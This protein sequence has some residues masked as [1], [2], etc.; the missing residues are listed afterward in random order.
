M[1]LCVPH[2]VARGALQGR[3]TTSDCARSSTA[4]GC[5]VVAVLPHLSP[6]R[7]VA[8]A[9]IA[10]YAPFRFTKEHEWVEYTEGKPDMTLGITDYAQEVLPAARPGTCALTWMTGAR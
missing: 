10:A 8:D 2:R 3:S 1:L 6:V 7:H 5:G 9:S 4:F